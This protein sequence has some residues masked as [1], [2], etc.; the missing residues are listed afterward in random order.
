MKSEITQTWVWIELS[1]IFILLPSCFLAGVLP[2]TMI[3][4][5]LW[6]VFGYAVFRLRREGVSL[7]GEGVRLRELKK[8]AGRFA[9]IAPAIILIA[10]LFYP[11]RLF[12]F[13][14]KEPVLWV[15]IMVAYPIVSVWVQEMVFRRWFYYR[16]RHLF[17]TKSTFILANAA[18]FSY[19]HIVFL[20][21]VAL[22]LSFL[23]GI[24]FAL[25]YLN[26]RSLLLVSI[27][28][29]LYGN[30]LFTIGL[31]SFFYHGTAP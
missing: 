21:P 1:L 29:A 24:L 31:G 6:A 26:S 17:A 12:D 7:R 16:Y 30:L 11:D 4:P 20:N 15:L 28:H 19:A 5:S 27:E 10:L 23:G 2:K 13:V 8:V 25:T 22:L 9:L 18:L 3:M 14:R